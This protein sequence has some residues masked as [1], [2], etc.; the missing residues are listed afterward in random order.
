MFDLHRY[1]DM[2]PIGAVNTSESNRLGFV[3]RVSTVGSLVPLEFEPLECRVLAQHLCERKRPARSQRV[4]AQH[5][6][7]RHTSDQS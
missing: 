4:A 7:Y 3:P 2:Q 6:L 1:H 5:Q